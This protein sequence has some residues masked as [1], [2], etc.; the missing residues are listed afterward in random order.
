MAADGYRRRREGPKF[1]NVSIGRLRTGAGADRGGSGPE[2]ADQD[3]R[4]SAAKG[5]SRPWPAHNTPVPTLLWAADSRSGAEQGRSS[6]LRGVHQR[7]GGPSFDPPL[8]P[9]P[10]VRRGASPLPSYTRAPLLSYLEQAMLQ[11][12]SAGGEGLQEEPLS[13]CTRGEL[14]F[15][16]QIGSRQR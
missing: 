16:A 4:I 2:R 14:R 8:S 5:R 11:E 9:S 13:S 10:L 7:G 15:Q 1:Q 12:E 3:P 6:H